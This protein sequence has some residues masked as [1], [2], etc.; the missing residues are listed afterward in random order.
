MLKLVEKYGIKKV[1]ESQSEVN[2]ERTLINFE[3]SKEQLQEIDE[4]LRRFYERRM[5][6][7]F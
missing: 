1:N 5:R 2:P 4:K 6:Q 3:I 7:I